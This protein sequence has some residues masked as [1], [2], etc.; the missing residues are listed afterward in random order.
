MTNN[1]NGQ[2]LSRQDLTRLPTPYGAGRLADH[3]IVAHV[4]PRPSKGITDLL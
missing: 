1:C 2:S 3:V 4:Q